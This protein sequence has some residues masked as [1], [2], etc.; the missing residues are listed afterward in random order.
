VIIALTIVLLLGGG[1]LSSLAKQLK[2]DRKHAGDVLKGTEVRSP[3]LEVLE[4][5]VKISAESGKNSQKLLD[6]GLKAGRD[7]DRPSV[8]I[9]SM[10][11]TH[12]E[13]IAQLDRSF[14]DQR[15]ALHGL[16]T[17]EQWDAVF[18]EDSAD[19]RSK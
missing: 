7:H 19:A 16:L 3:A 18:Q 15:D 1:A 2:L 8:E 17:R 11:E 14:L 10:L 4:S 5:M 13:R 9:G 12:A 6:E